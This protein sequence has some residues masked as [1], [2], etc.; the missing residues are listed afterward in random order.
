MIISNAEG[1]SLKEVS[2][3]VGE[4]CFSC[5]WLVQ[6]LVLEKLTYTGDRKILECIM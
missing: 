1:Q 2:I 6:K 3:G 4:E 5:M